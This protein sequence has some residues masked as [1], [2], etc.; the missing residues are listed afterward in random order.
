MVTKITDTY[1]IVNIVCADTIS[2]EN[3]LSVQTPSLQS[4]CEQTPYQQYRTGE[5]G[6]W[7]NSLWQCEVEWGVVVDWSHCSSQTA[8]FPPTSPPPA[9]HR[10]WHFHQTQIPVLGYTRHQTPVWVIRRTLD[11][12]IHTSHIPDTNTRLIFRHQPAL[13]DNNMKLPRHKKS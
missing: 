1:I 7:W 3:I 4:H 13:F 2:A 10:Y 8:P 5:S 6:I 11:I 9:R 12:N